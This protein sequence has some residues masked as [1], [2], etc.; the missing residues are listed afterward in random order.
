MQIA[1]FTWLKS[2]RGIA[3]GTIR[4]VEA[5]LTAN[6]ATIPAHWNA[7]VRLSTGKAHGVYAADDG[8]RFARIEDA[9]AAILLQHPDVGTNIALD[10]AR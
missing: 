3:H 7:G 4:A 2:M 1:T 8:L 10:E 6:G 5:Q 9:A